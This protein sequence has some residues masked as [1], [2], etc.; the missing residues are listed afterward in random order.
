MA[1]MGF[2]KDADW[3]E[4]KI[5][6]PDAIPEKHKR[7]SDIIQRKFNLKIVKLTW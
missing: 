5:Y 2:E 1:K 7:I 6:I 3:V 4:Y